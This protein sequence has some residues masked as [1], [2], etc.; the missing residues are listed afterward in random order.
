MTPARSL[1][2][3]MLAVLLL[4]VARPIGGV[5]QFPRGLLS[6]EAKAGSCTIDTRPLNFGT[7]DALAT[8]DTDALGEVMYTCSRKI[9]SVLNVRI[10]VSR[11]GSGSFDR[12]MASGAEQL[13]YNLY[14][15]ADHR[16]VWGD[17]S[18]GTDYYFNPSPPN[19][20]RVTVPAYGRLFG[21]QDVMAGTYTDILQVTIL[22]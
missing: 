15:D 14:L 11:G 3:A 20:T 2:I 6:A 5:E 1:S 4:I 9:G 7:Y 10:N 22:F 16:K 8:R 21:M 19:N 17:G 12:R 13:S 18:S